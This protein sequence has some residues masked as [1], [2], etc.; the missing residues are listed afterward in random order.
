MSLVEMLIVMVVLTII[1]AGLANVLVS[2]TRAQY[3]L[4]TRLERAAERADRAVQ[5]RV[6]GPLRHERDDPRL[7]RGRQLLAPGPVHECRGDGTWCVTSGVLQR[8][9]AA[10]CSGT[11]RVSSATS[12]PRRRSAS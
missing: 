6:R 11:S 12:R 7:G 4:S 1:M 9:S 8:Y 3:D 10:T 5:D 2:G